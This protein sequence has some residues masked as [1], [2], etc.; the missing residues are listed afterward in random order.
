MLDQYKKL[1]IISKFIIAI[2]C[3][4]TIPNIAF[5]AVITV[6]QNG[7]G[8]YDNIPQAIANAFPG[9]TIEVYPGDTTNL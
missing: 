4:L 9:D 5:S 1:I 7:V 3:Y 2:V 6:K 8:D